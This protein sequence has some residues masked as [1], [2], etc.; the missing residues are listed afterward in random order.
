MSYLSHVKCN[1]SHIQNVKAQSA[2]TS[3]LSGQGHHWWQTIDFFSKTIMHKMLS[4]PD[5]TDRILHL[6]S[7]IISLEKFVK[8]LSN[9]SQNIDF[10]HLFNIYTWHWLSLDEPF[11]TNWLHTPMKVSWSCDVVVKRRHGKTN[12]LIGQRNVRLTSSHD[13][14][15]ST[16]RP[17][18]CGRHLGKLKNH[19]STYVK[20]WRCTFWWITF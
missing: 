18:H 3:W 6:C 12:A 20:V 14:G 4:Y 8:M 19:K 9:T 13:D 1:L 15:C 7:C 10:S 11:K 2:Y 16:F 5:T 17:N